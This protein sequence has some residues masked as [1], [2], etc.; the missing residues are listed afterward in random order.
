M[1]VS[2]DFLLISGD[3]AWKTSILLVS[4]CERGGRANHSRKLIQQTSRHL[5]CSLCVAN[6]I[7]CD[8]ANDTPGHLLRAYFSTEIRA[9]E[10]DM[11]MRLTLG[12]VIAFDGI[13]LR[14]PPWQIGKWFSIN[15]IGLIITLGYTRAL[16]VRVDIVFIRRISRRLILIESSV[17]DPCD[18][19]YIWSIT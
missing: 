12:H 15:A 16:N 5:L 13:I 8:C 17:W 2:Q 4:N 19:V 10:R 7:Y 3:E 11:M 18:K 1:R 14:Y 6:R 9:C